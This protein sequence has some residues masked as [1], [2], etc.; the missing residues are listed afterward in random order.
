MEIVVIIG[1]AEA[2]EFG[3]GKRYFYS[4]VFLPG[5]DGKFKKW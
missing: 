5:G 3:I 2:G 1:N 4:S